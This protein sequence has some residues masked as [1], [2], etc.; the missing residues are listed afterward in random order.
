M[1]SDQNIVDVKSHSTCHRGEFWILQMEQSCI[2]KPFHSLTT[3]DYA[4]FSV[5][6]LPGWIATSNYRDMLLRESTTGRIS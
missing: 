4:M 2:L 3:E 6:L 1:K 5:L